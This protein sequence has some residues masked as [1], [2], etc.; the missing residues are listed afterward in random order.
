[1]PSIASVSVEARL[2]FSSLSKDFARLQS[3]AMGQ[4]AK[5][6]KTFGRS[7]ASSVKSTPMRDVVTGM[8]QGVGQQLTQMGMELGRSFGSAISSSVAA[9]ADFERLNKTLLVV[10]GSSAAVAKEQAFLSSTISRMSLPVKEATQSY[11]E[12]MAASK[13]TA[14]EGERTQ[15]I[16]MGLTLAGKALGLS[17]EA[18][19]RAFNAVQQMMS[20]GKVSAEELRGQLG[21]ALPGA[22]QLF[23]K[24]IGVSAAQLDKLLENGQVGTDALIHFTEALIRT[25]GNAGNATKTLSDEFTTFNNKIVEAQKNFGDLIKPVVL[26]ALENISALLSGI[27]V[28]LDSA[29]GLVSLVAKWLSDSKDEAAALGSA[30]GDVVNSAMTYTKDLAQGI[31][32]YFDRYPA[33]LKAVNTAAGFLNDT[34]DLMKATVNA[35]G[36]TF[37]TIFETIGKIAQ[38]LDEMKFFEW[39]N[40]SIQNIGGGLSGAYNQLAGNINDQSGVTQRAIEKGSS[41]LLFPVAGGG[42]RVNMVGGGGVFGAPR[43]GGR[44]HMG[45]DY[46]YKTGTPLAATLTGT[47]KEVFENNG[48]YGLVLEGK[49]GNDTIETQIFHMDT[50]SVKR[51]QTVTQGQR[52]GT[53]GGAKGSWGSTGE[54]LDLKIKKNGVFLDPRTVAFMG[55][56]SI[57]DPISGAAVAASDTSPITARS[58]APWKPQ[59]SEADAKKRKKDADDAARA[60]RRLIEENDRKAAQA[61]SNSRG[62]RDQQF[63]IATQQGRAGLSGAALELWNAQRSGTSALQGLYDQRADLVS[64]R[65]IKV[66]DGVTGGIDYTAAIK[67]VDG[68]IAA[69][70]KLNKTNEEGIKATNAR[71]EAEKKA[72]ED[73]RKRQENNERRSRAMEYGIQ[74]RDQGIGL[75][76][77]MSLVGLTGSN[78]TWAEN[79]QSQEAELRIVD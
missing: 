77:R 62:L 52:I 2:D 22:Y 66:R 4:G 65:G 30:I 1:M 37:N 54:H 15:R 42:A 71:E 38:K 35:I 32:D 63:D 58:L 5:V 46:D 17:N 72:E 6:G 28:D 12:L 64:A 47:I 69:Q 59:A 9:S 67:A 75:S 53:T 39:A 79:A 43:S 44:K 50:I 16:F 57:G 78:K 14:L 3:E 48:E 26:A 74:S 68:L 60:A 49:I 29:R 10:A 73:R 76:N 40:Q 51:G 61:A 41:G 11:V 7:L 24:S 19:A 36:A 55:S 23:A 31:G 18:Q 13:G 20:K 70:Q 8:F 33:M 25:Y 34:L 45:Q 27:G 21:E 56:N